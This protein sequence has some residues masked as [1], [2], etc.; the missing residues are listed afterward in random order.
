MPA[1]SATPANG[2]DDAVITGIR[3]AVAS[4][5]DRLGDAGIP[6]EATATFVPARR[7]LGFT[8]AA[9]LVPAGRAWRLG[10]FLV[11]RAGTLQQAGTTTRAVEP[12]RASHHSVS[13]ER[14][15]EYRA[16]A[17]AGRFVRGETINVDAV[18]I[19]LG[20]AALESSRGALFV[21]GGRALVRWNPSGDDGS[22]IDFEAY[23]AE[24]VGL[25]LSPPAGA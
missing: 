2:D 13:A 21:S 20:R 25:A 3:R 17:Y 1:M 12:G 4:A 15:R 6:D 16:A 14:R 22:A 18:P 19:T 8:R 5:A 23:L 24:R 10:V 9:R 11:D 7:I